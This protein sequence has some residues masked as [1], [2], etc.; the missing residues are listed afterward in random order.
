MHAST[1]FTPSL[2]YQTGQRRFWGELHGSSLSLLIANTANRHTAPVIVVCNDMPA[3]RQL[4]HEL[5][6][7]CPSTIPI[8]ILPD[9]ETLPYDQ[10]SP[11]Q[12]IISERLAT[13]YSL[14]SL[15]H[16]IILLPISTL[17]HRFLPK[18]YLQTH[19][20]VLRTKQTLI[21]NDF[22]QQLIDSGYQCVNT[23]LEHGEFAIRGSL[24]D[25]Y[26]M[27]S[28]AAFR[29]D[30]FADEID[31]IRIFDPE[32]QRS[33][34]PIS[35]IQM[36]PAR[37]CPLDQ[38]AINH[39][40]EQYQQY[41]NTNDTPVYQQIKK[42][43]GIPGI[44]YYLPLFFTHTSSLF[45]YLPAK[46]LFFSQPNMHTAAEHFYTDITQ[47]YQQ[48][49]HDIQRPLLAPEQ[50]FLAIEDIFLQLKSFYRIEIDHLRSLHKHSDNFSSL[51]VPDLQLESHNKN[52]LNKL[53]RLIDD[54]QG[55]ILF[56]TETAGRR[57]SLLELLQ[58]IDIY[59][60]SQANWQHFLDNS[61]PIGI[62]I[63]SLQQGF[64]IH[65]PAIL[66]IVEDQL[67][68]KQVMQ[69]RRRQKETDAA[70]N[71][72]N[73]LAELE[74]D[75]PVVHEDNGVGRYKGL[76]KITVN[77]MSTEFLTLEYA[78]KDKLYVPVSSLH[79]IN[80]YTGALPEK[81]PLHKLGSGQWEKAK[82]KAK[83][84]IH[85]VATE[86]LAI[87]AQREAQQGFTYHLHR[88]AYQ[89]F[90]ST[91]PFEETVDQSAAIENILHDMQKPQPMDRLICG[92]VGFG[93]T[94]VAMRAAFIAI[95]NNKQVAVL[96]PT[97]L[98]ARQ[99]DENFSDRFA[100]WPVKVASISRFNSSKQLQKTLDDIASGKIDIIIGT[101]KLLQ[102]T[103][104]FH[105]LGLLII[106]EEHRFGVR[107]KE[108]FKALRSEIDILTMTATPIP[109][110][111]SMALN[112]VRDFSIIATPPAHRLSVKTF[113]YEWSN[114]IIKEAC[115][116]ELMRGGQIYFLHN[117]VSTIAKKAREL[118]ALLPEAE[119]HIAHG[120]MREKELEHV[121]SS[122]Y[123]QRFQILVCT[124]IIETGIDIPTANTIII[125]RAD[126]FGLA[127]L[128]Q[129]RGRVG[130]SHHRAYAYLIIPGKNLLTKD[131]EKRLDAIS[132]VEEL[133]TGFTLA[134]H[135][136]E[137]RGAGEI[138]G[139]QQSGQMQEIGFTLY[140]EL[141]DRTVQS[142]K[143]GQSVNAS[144]PLHTECE[145]QLHAPALI[146]DDYIAD[147]H[148]RLFMYQ[149]IA[150]ATD[151]H[152][153]KEL[154]IELIDR[155]GL[156]PTACQQLI[157]QAELKLL[158]QPIGITRID[159]SSEGGSIHFTDNP[160]IDPMNIIR[161]IQR[162]AAFFK[163]DNNNKLR[164]LY[165]QDKVE[166]RISYLHTLIK[167][168]KATH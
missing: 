84:K 7:F 35:Q 164:L 24:I 133:G 120:Q 78:N 117:E 13:L 66:L 76:Q 60:K 88:Q 131:A 9:W 94:E 95:Q 149:R 29:I 141:L 2:H 54:Y 128:Y 143:Q 43:I 50:L 114:D 18:D 157:A 1:I 137:I 69:R 126:K 72:I 22:K 37:E 130:R 113:V 144:I 48:Y 56:I 59:P 19:S 5:Q 159:Y 53:Q 63:G 87:Y 103:V 110:T 6:F 47:R 28:T 97:T 134:S 96:V 135:D 166:K 154:Q 8:F 17:M 65:H 45:D 155:F 58:R 152:T 115:Q 139:D 92:D 34:Q 32:S 82:Q 15:T 104:T 167:Q 129:L 36:L 74:L 150:K 75:M 156:L 80:R 106:D 85:D 70:D 81:A 79:L 118:Q 145:I 112:S 40:C 124:T 42:G 68:G 148:S 33:S 73:S 158:A 161:L 147:V 11:H 123:H 51:P 12:D 125:N 162:Q 31:S 136:L 4:Y 44:E 10:F 14:P 107:Q 83:E 168:L 111:L 3:T 160:A 64:Q 77:G 86:L 90:V 121:M 57:E 140:S 163:L 122:F 98:L 127:Q 62:T 138:L 27:G 30:I 108:Q 116:R 100:D 151:K 46:S 38:T 20:L 16:G 89:A 39:F 49:S 99:H 71:I 109:R 142:L 105:N 67:Y 23:V 102:K 52:P 146:P 93:K 25:I 41:F 61:D 132:S 119:I 165:K 55:R 153:L 21:I 91:F 101:H 26:P